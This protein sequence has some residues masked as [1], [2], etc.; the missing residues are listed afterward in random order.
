M[1]SMKP[2]LLAA[3]LAVLASDSQAWV[4]PM[5]SSAV[6]SPSVRSILKMADDNKNVQIT[7]GRKEIMFDAEKGRFFE[8]GMETEECIPDEEYCSVDSETGERIRLTVAEKERIFLDALQVSLFALLIDRLKPNST[9]THSIIVPVLL[10]NRP[11]AS[12]R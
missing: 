2:A 11:T 6:R 4:S 9:D 7:S 5:R 8:T 1:M 12:W 10:R 3:V